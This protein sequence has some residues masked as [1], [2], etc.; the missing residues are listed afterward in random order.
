MFG[1]RATVAASGPADMSVLSD[2][3]RR[4]RSALNSMSTK[5]RN[6]LVFRFLLDYSEQETAIALDCAP[7][8]VKSR[9]SRALTK[10]RAHSIFSQEE[11]RDAK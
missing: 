5:D 7:G 2:E 9:T 1:R 8:T 10:L 4:L 6:V 11:D 3:R